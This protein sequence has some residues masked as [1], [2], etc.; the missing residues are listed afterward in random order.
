MGCGGRREEMRKGREGV[1]SEQ[2]GEVGG[3]LSAARPTICSN[4]YAINT[5]KLLLTNTRN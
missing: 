3:S 4:F 2:R 1:G 5:K